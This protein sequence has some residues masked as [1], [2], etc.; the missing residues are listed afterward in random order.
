MLGTLAKALS[1]TTTLDVD[2][3]ELKTILIF[4]G[5]GLL[6]SLAV[7]MAYGLDPPH[8]FSSA[9]AKIRRKNKPAASRL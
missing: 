4:C 1:R 2:V 8:P 7:A 5:A 6:V 9:S 3:D